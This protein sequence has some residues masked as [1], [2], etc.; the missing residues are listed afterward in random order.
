MN[1]YQRLA[2]LIEM[3][4]VIRYHPTW[5]PKRLAEYFEISEKRIFDDINELNAANIPVVFNGKGYSLLSQHS[6]PPA[7][8]TV[9]EALALLIGATALG[10]KTEAQAARSASMKLLDLLP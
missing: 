1:K 3:I 9:D 6:L 5:G 4:S 8:F 2:R 7:H 10:T